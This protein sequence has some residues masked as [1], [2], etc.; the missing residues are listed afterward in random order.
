MVKNYFRGVAISTI[1]ALILTAC[2]QPVPVVPSTDSGAAP[3]AA[4]TADP[5]GQASGE[6]QPGGVWVEASIADA[7][8]LNP[9]LSSETGSS[10][11]TNFLF[12][13]LIGT[14][15]FTGEVTADG[16]LA[17]SWEVSEDSLVWTFT[18]REGVTWSDGEPVD[19]EDFKFTYDAVAS[20]LVETP[21][22]SNLEGIASI[23]APDPRTVVVTFETNR[24]DGLLNLG[25]PILPS[26]L[27]APDFSDIMT[28]ALNQE[29]TVSSGPLLFQSWSRDDNITMARNETYWEGAPYMDGRI[30]RI[31]PDTGTQLTQLQNGEIDTMS[32]SPD[33]L[34]TV[35]NLPDI[36]VYRYE[37]DGYSFIALNL[38]NPDN[39]QPGQDADGNLIEQDP[40]PIL[41]DL[42]VRK[43]IAHSLDYQTIIDNV[44]LGQGYPLASNVLPAISWAHDDTLQ[45]YDYD[46]ELA[47]SLLEEAGWVDEDGDGVREKDGVPLSLSLLTN[48]GNTVREDIGALVQ[49]QLSQL[50]FDINFEAIDFGVL[51]E[52]MLGQT[53][54]MVI[55]GWTNTGT[56]PNDENLW[57]T[58]YDT[59]GSGFNFVSYHNPEIDELLTQAVTVSGC[60]PEDRAP[61]YKEIQQ[62]IHNDL[63][64][65]MLSGTVGNT[66]YNTRWQGID[67]GPW[68]FAYNIH[69]WYL[70]P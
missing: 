6:A 69:Q 19:A 27:Y 63:P 54:D 1:L 68:S 57:A 70:A 29:P 42:N 2:A 43:A 12:L 35:Q 48:A 36:E 51:V 32:V 49:D 50:G 33:Q 67:P 18:L 7:E 66:A 24:C 20:D 45:P 17:E 34:A 64:Y 9:I 30:I 16:A 21:R 60:A 25:L 44:Y 40:H 41:S 26:H 39:P 38:A 4:G 13:S 11:V 61:L 8:N 23:E 5:A 22:K 55:I 47:I 15:P 52:R 37:D 31:I 10:A 46:Q 62:I 59:P 53:Y 28:S 3:S 65:V 56:D 58:K 14:D